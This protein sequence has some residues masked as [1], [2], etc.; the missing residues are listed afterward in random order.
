MFKQTAHIP[1]SLFPALRDCAKSSC[2]PMSQP[3]RTIARGTEK[4]PSRNRGTMRHKV[5]LRQREKIK[6]GCLDQDKDAELETEENRNEK[7]RKKRWRRK[8]DSRKRK[9]EREIRRKKKTEKLKF[10][11]TDRGETERAGAPRGRETETESARRRSAS[12]GASG[13]GTAGAVGVPG[14]DPPRGASPCRG[15]PSSHIP[16]GFPH[17]R[18]Q[19]VPKAPAFPAPL[20]RQGWRSYFSP[21]PGL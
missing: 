6:D 21:P 12:W 4:E 11:K 3:R 17:T 20:P 16:P 1:R 15:G 13:P 2:I 8:G 19:R 18:H 9:L 14:A 10:E 7:K 5:C